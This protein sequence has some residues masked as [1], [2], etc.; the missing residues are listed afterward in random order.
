MKALNMTSHWKLAALALPVFLAACAGAP[1]TPTPN[2]TMELPVATAPEQ[3][4][5]KPDRSG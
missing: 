5:V 2:T 1:P 3:Q 4:P